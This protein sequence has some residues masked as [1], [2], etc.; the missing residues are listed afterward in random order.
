VDVGYP[1]QIGAS[2][3]INLNTLEHC[4]RDKE[5][6]AKSQITRTP[7]VFMHNGDA[8]TMKFNNIIAYTLPPQ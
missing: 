8:S 2:K 7:T 1:V 6:Y 4:R 5:K 3:K